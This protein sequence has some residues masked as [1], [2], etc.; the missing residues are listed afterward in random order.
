MDLVAAV[1]A[2][3]QSLELAQQREGALDH[4]AGEAEA[5]AVLGLAAGDLR[6]DP[7]LAKVTYGTGT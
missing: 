5:R 7:A 6:P 3:R 4:P 1:E 2:D